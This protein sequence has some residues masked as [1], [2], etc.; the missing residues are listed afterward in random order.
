[1]SEANSEAKAKAE[2]IKLGLDVQARQATEC[3]ARLQTHRMPGRE[4]SSVNTGDFRQN[5]L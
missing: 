4:K 5:E 3:S 1:M 2:V